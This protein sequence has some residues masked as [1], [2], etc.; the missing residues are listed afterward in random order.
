MLHGAGYSAILLLAELNQAIHHLLRLGTLLILGEAHIEVHL[1]V[2]E[3]NRAVL[4]ESQRRGKHLEHLGGGAARG[5]RV[6]IHGGAAGN[7][8]QQSLIAPIHWKTAA[9]REKPPLTHSRFFE[10]HNV[11][12]ELFYGTEPQP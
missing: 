5:S 11:Y 9:G 12:K 3:A 7:R 8:G 6:H 2:I 10:E 1:N 4:V